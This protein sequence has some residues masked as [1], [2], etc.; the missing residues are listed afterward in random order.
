MKIC[1]HSFRSYICTPKMSQEIEIINKATELFFQY[2]V[3]SV[4]MDDL[5]KDLGVSKKTLY[6]F[7]Q[8]KSDL[9]KKA[10]E[11]FMKTQRVE[12]NYILNQKNNAIDE[13]VFIGKINLR[14]LKKIHPSSMYDLEKYYP[15][16][17]QIVQD[18]KLEFMHDILSKNIE[19]GKKEKLYREEID[20]NLM[21]KFYTIIIEQLVLPRQFPSTSF[22]FANLYKQFMKYHL[23]G[24]AS[25]NGV[26][27]IKTIDFENE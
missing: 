25:E 1:F 3:R 21:I 13:I 19:R 4:T 27:Y 26:A 8:N 2:G 7:V 10:L 15:E 22:D 20:S 12:I 23:S 14:N 11:N 16:S 6:Q 9:V 17:W 24:I 18:Y 5:S